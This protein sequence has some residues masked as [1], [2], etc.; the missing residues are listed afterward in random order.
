MVTG[1]PFRAEATG[2]AR[3]VP[4]L[5][6]VRV[7]TIAALACCGG[8]Q[9][10][11][12][13]AVS[14]AEGDDARDVVDA[15][16]PTSQETTPPTVSDCTASGGEAPIRSPGPD[17][18]TE[19]R[20][21]PSITTTGIEC[22]ENSLH[23]AYVPSAS[24]RERLLLFLPGTD[25][26]PAQYTLLGQTVAAAGDH[27]ILLDYISTRDRANNGH[28]C[29]LPFPGC[30]ENDA[31]PTR[32]RE[33]SIFGED[34]GPCATINWENSILNRAESLIEWLAQTYPAD[35]W[36]EFLVADGTIDWPSVTIGGHSQ[37]TGNA[38]MIAQ[39]FPVA[40]ACLIAGPVDRAAVCGLPV[41]ATWLTAPFVTAADRFYALE[42]ENDNVTEAVYV[43]DNLDNYLNLPGPVAYVEDGPIP[44]GVHQVWTR[45]NGLPIHMAL[46]M[47]S[48]TPTDSD[49]APILAPVWRHVCVE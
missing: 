42:A 43:H 4:T 20:V 49:G 33:E 25:A 48:A 46:A 41:P 18:T 47:D 17:G 40:R 16:C 1:T 8:G 5:F 32:V 29:F 6:T 38:A 27:V 19:I 44:A 7:I 3:A 23:V 37:G 21:R 22:E 31:C 30:S 28:V 36:A 15:A 35:G 10:V 9:G 14:D 45:A 34:R 13:G 11:P 2:F 39:R 24:R 12:D 26:S